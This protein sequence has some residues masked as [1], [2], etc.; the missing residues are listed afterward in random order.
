MKSIEPYIAIKDKAD[1]DWYWYKYIDKDKILY[2]Q[3]NVCYDRLTIDDNNADYPVFNDFLSEMRALIDSSDIDKL[4]IDLRNNGGGNSR[5][6]TPFI[7]MI[8]KNNELNK[9]GK[10]FVIVGR[11][12][13]SGGASAASDITTKLEAISIGEPTGGLVNCTGNT[14][15]VTLP[16]SKLTISYATEQFYFSSKYNGSFI[17]DIIVNQSI[18]SSKNY[19]DDIYETIAKFDIKS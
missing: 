18:E 4:V 15:K 2:F 19:I 3:Y 12:T 5:V 1:H 7:E 17:P 16:N 13:F 11:K 8:A 6:I 9:K 10:I 14:R